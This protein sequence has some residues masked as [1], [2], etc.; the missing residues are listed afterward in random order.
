MFSV[1][2]VFFILAMTGKFDVS[3]SVELRDQL[4]WL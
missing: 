1:D 4:E 3:G 2:P